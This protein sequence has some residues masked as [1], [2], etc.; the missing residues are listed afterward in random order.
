V[1]ALRGTLLQA[2]G[3]FSGAISLYDESLRLSKED[4]DEHTAISGNV[5]YNKAGALVSQG[6]FREAKEHLRLAIDKMDFLSIAARLDSEFK[7]LSSDKEYKAI[8]GQ[9]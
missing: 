1:A 6:K 7:P 8:T 4:H 2:K 3:D 5:L 9:G